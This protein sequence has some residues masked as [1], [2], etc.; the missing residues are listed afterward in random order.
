MY[1][2]DTNL[3]FASKDPNKLFSSLTH[4]LGYLKQWLD[5]NRFKS[6]CPQD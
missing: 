1:A 4:D 6:K 5:S 2:D 3:T